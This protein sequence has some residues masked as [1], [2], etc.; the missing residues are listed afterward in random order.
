MLLHWSKN[1]KSIP[2]W[3][4]AVEDDEEAEDHDTS[5]ALTLMDPF[6]P[7]INRT[8]EDTATSRLLATWMRLIPTLYVRVLSQRWT[9]RPWHRSLCT[10]KWNPVHVP[11]LPALLEGKEWDKP[12]EDLLSLCQRPVNMAIHAGLTR[13]NHIPETV[14]ERELWS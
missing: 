11:V 10:V 2:T 7:S 9:T 14:R 6:P 13:R 1:L 3:K 8:W 4:T 5:G 12:M